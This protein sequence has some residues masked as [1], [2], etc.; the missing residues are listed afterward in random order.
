MTLMRSNATWATL[1]A[2][3]VASAACSPA[4]DNG[5]G[6]GAPGSTTSGGS[7][8]GGAIATGG[9]GPSATGGSPANGGATGT[10]GSTAAGGS[11][12][13]G[14]A[15]GTGGSTAAGGSAGTGG[16]SGTGGAGMTP[17][18]ASAPGGNA[19]SGMYGSVPIKPVMSG[20]WLGKPANAD[21]SAGGPFVVLFS[22]PITCAEVSKTRG[23]I[24]TI[25]GGTQVMELIIGATEVGKDLKEKDGAGAG[26]FESNY[27]FGM[28]KLIEHKAS[29][30]TLTLT[31]YAPGKAVEG[32]FDINF[33]IGSATGT[34]HADWCPDGLEVGA[35]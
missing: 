14:G 26:M 4:A 17:D 10:G 16:A 31:S 12:G 5:G 13:T 24:A 1:S 29:S 30:G 6:A 35:P 33:G 3:L 7:G 19:V 27:I 21:E 8:A 15:S 22:A 20:L 28:T 9:S 25:P 11:M 18:A 2:F 32:K 34:F 23:W